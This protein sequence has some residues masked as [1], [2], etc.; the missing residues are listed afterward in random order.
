M[1]MQAKTIIYYSANSEDPKFEAKICE[2]ILKQKGYIPIISVSQKPMDFGKNICV[3][4]IGHSYLNE[5]RQI[6]IG[7][8]AAET[9]YIVFAESDFLYPES[10]F[11]FEPKGANLYRYNNVWIIFKDPKLYSYRRKDSSVG[12][13][14][15]KKEYVIKLLEEFLDG[16]PEWFDGEITPRDKNGKVRKDVFKVPFEPFGSEI[17]C[18]SFKTGQ[19]MRR[20][21]SVMRGR[22]NLQMNLP[23]WGRAG[24]LRKEYL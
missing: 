18:I 9:P 5:F 7:A 11:A 17:P 19:G 20:Q 3:G 16:A 6:L 8:K 23:Y 14:I 24:D 22:D 21:T 1:S 12:A 2:N 15:G 4:E 10:Y 13:Q